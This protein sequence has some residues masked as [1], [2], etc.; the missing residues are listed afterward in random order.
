MRCHLAQAS[1]I[2]KRA[3]GALELEQIFRTVKDTTCP[4]FYNFHMHTVCS[5]GRLQP[6]ELMQQAID[7]GLHGLA[8]TD[9]HS[10]QGYYQARQWFEDWQWRNPRSAMVRQPDRPMLKLWTGI[11]INA[12]LL[13]IGVHILGYGF[14]ADHDALQPYLQRNGVSHHSS[15]Y[16]AVAVIGAI[17]D[18]GGLAVLAHPSRGR[19]QRSPEALIQ[20]AAALGIDGVEVYYAYDN[21]SPWRPSPEQTTQVLPL[22]RKLGLLT[23]CGTDTHGRSLLQRI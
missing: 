20:E 3:K 18:A 21:P 8:I 14:Y 2:R 23:T 15:D 4:R 9:H 12:E 16:A 19:Y 7:L 22:V 11:E 17:Q 5:D 13:G 1:A 10:V 6:E